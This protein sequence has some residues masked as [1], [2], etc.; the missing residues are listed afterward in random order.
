MQDVVGGKM[1]KNT[2][3][4]ILKQSEVIS[5]LQKCAMICSDCKDEDSLT[6]QIRSNL[7]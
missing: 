6:E 4:A 2:D 5:D 1:T 7:R 3:C